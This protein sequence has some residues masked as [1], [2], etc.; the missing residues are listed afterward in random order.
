MNINVFSYWNTLLGNK[1]VKHET[2]AYGCKF[3]KKKIHPV[4]SYG[5]KTCYNRFSI[6]IYVDVFI[7]K[8]NIFF[9]L[10]ICFLFN[11]L[12]GI[13]LCTDRDG[14]IILGTCEEYIKGPG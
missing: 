5:I 9:I 12:V 3:S 7:N 11:L 13:F 4:K 2:D 8:M 14:N 10:L 6:Y 1:E